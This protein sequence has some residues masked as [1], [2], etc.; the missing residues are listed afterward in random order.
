[1]SLIAIS[2]LLS[3]GSA[4]AHHQPQFE[5]FR[6]ALITPDQASS[7]R[8]LGLKHD[9]FSSAVLLLRDN[10]SASLRPAMKRVRDSGLELYYWI[11]IGRNPGMAKAHPEWM[12]SLQGH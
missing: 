4:P 12:A 2:I 8:L 6:G 1:M 10:E 5:G 11:E 7:E 3:I 9:G